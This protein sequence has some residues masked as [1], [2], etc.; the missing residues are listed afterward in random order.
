MS[1]SLFSRLTIAAAALALSTFAYADSEREAGWEVGLDVVY[2]DAATYDFEGG[3]KLALDDDL[4]F[5]FTFGY[6]ISPRLELQ[7]AL[8]WADVD[9]AANIVRDTNGD[10]RP[11]GAGTRASG[12]LESFTPRMNLQI[13]LFDQPFTPFVMGGVGYSFIDTNIPNGLPQ[14][15]CWWDPWYGYIC[16]TYQSTKTSDKFVYQVGAGI[17]WDLGE[18]SSLRLAYEVHFIDA[19]D[20]STGTPPAVNQFKLGFSYRY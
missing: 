11:D 14:T 3:S 4:S 8:D 2:Q 5:S 12:S 16:T 6:R 19:I 10:G 18:Y 17:R 1:T 13:N 9:Y 7:F 15:G 20:T